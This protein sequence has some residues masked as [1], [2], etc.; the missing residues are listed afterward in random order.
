MVDIYKVKIAR[1]CLQKYGQEDFET[2][3]AANPFSA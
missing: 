3:L 1:S 2:R